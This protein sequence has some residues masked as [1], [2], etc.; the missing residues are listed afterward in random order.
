MSELNYWIV[1]LSAALALNL[2]PGPDL[3]YVLSST[4]SEGRRNGIAASCGVC[5]G[6]LVH[7]LA[8]SAG[9]ATI[10]A[11]S[12]MSFQV[13][14][15]IGGAYLGYIG[16]TTIRHRHVNFSLPDNRGKT[17]RS[18][19]QAFRQ[20][21]LID[22]LNPKVAIFFLA[23]LPQFVRSD[24]GH[25]GVQLA[26]LGGMIIVIAIVVELGL[27]WCATWARERLAGPGSPAHWIQM[28]LGVMLILLG[29]KLAL[30]P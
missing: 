7:V 19:W 29:A 20:G 17:A 1:F 3:I 27:V 4:L 21:V 26:M 2:S 30:L 22:V 13:I 14:K 11:Q 10:L 23:F 24:K 15:W 9:L 12:A 16:I 25:F 5:V 18:A 8:A 28:I 6:A